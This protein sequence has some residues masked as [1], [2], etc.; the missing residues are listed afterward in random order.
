MATPSRRGAS[1]KDRSEFREL[2]SLSSPDSTRGNVIPPSP[3]DPNRMEEAEEPRSEIAASSGSPEGSES[4]HP[5]SS[6][7]LHEDRVATPRDVMIA[8]T[9]GLE[10]VQHG[11]MLVAAEGQLRLANRVAAAILQKK[12]GIAIA[13]TGLVADRA[14]DTR[15]LYK[16]LE[17]AINSPERGEPEDSPL[18]LQRKNARHSLIVRVIPG[19]GLDCWPHSDNRTALLKLY[20]QDLGLIVDERALSALYGLTK[21]EAVLAARLAQGKSIEE[22]AA[23]LFISAHTARTHLKRIFMK[24]DTHRQ[25]ELVVRMLLTVL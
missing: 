23:E 6:E 13:R 20:D 9:Y 21:G 7:P 1:D 5:E 15:L 3:S 19:P 2:P 16:L 22:A 4:L 17:D 14:S 11:A 25:T 10:L 18:T 8:L 24:T 12:D